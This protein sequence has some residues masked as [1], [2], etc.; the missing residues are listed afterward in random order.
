[1]SDRGISG[2][3]AFLE[4]WVVEGFLVRAQELG[5]PGVIEGKGDEHRTPALGEANG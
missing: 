2:S 3:L 5:S 1:M 4:V